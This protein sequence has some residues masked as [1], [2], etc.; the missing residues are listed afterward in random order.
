MKTQNLISQVA[1]AVTTPS[2]WSANWN[3]PPRVEVNPPCQLNWIEQ[4]HICQA[5]YIDEL[6][7]IE[8]HIKKEAPAP[9]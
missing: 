8:L 6:G 1:E 5:T 9:A 4:D 3:S 7:T 2:A